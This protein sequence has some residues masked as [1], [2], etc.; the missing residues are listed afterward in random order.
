MHVR[1]Y[2]DQVRKWLPERTDSYQEA[3]FRYGI[4][5]AL[6]DQQLKRQEA[7]LAKKEET[8][9]KQLADLEA[10]AW[11][12]PPPDSR[13]MFMNKEQQWVD[14]DGKRFPQHEARLAMHP[15]QHQINLT[16]SQLA[17]DATIG[18]LIRTIRAGVG[19]DYRGASGIDFL[20]QQAELTLSISRSAPAVREALTNE[21]TELTSCQSRTAQRQMSGP[22]FICLQASG[23]RMIE[24]WQCS[25]KPS[26][27]HFLKCFF[28]AN[29]ITYAAAQELGWKPFEALQRL[30]QIRK[31]QNSA[32]MLFVL[33]RDR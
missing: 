25:N 11:R 18:P 24:D 20:R 21:S 31:Q 8:L 2:T 26:D 6:F 27:A 19:A 12:Q 28:E 30:E 17:A 32:G 15:A 5:Q 10:R 4:A 16:T 33:Q 13:L 23:S 29:A 9:K 7:A 14:R 22:Q 1:F 3:F